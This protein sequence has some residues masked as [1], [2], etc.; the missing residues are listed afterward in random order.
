MNDNISEPI[1]VPIEAL[2]QQEF[3]QNRRISFGIW[4]KLLD[5]LVTAHGRS[6]GVFHNN[7]KIRIDDIIVDGD[8]STI[9][10]VIYEQEI[11]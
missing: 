3:K 9:D 11:N 8:Y 10:G 7:E 5:S 6:I 4:T 2:H 1:R